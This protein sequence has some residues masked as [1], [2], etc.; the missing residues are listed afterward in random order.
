VAIAVGVAV[1]LGTPTPVES[2]ADIEILSFNN[3]MPENLNPTPGNFPGDGCGTSSGRFG[4]GEINSN[5]INGRK[6]IG[7]INRR[8]STQK[9]VIK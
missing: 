8:K 6:L 9:T 7:I 3:Q 5:Q 2:P 4:G 1:P